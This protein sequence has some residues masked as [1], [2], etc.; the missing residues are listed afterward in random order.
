MPPG[1]SQP[2]AVIALF[3]DTEP[4]DPAFVRVEAVAAVPGRGGLLRFAEPVKLVLADHAVAAMQEAELPEEK[5]A[6]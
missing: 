6:K 2:V 3:G 4:G 5:P 1:A